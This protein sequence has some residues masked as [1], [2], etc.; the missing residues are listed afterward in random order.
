M[1]KKL[2]TELIHQ[3]PYFKY[4][5]DKFRTDDGQEHNYYYCTTL[6]GAITV[7]VLED[8]RLI[9]VRQYRYVV[10][11]N[12]IEFPCGGIEEGEIPS[13]TIA[14]ELLEETG[15]RAEDF[16]KLGEFSSALS[17]FKDTCSIYVATGLKQVQEPTSEI[18]GS[19]EIL[20]R[21]VD[22]FKDMIKRG[23]IIDGDTLSAWAI[24]QEY[25]SGLI[26][27]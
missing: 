23:E 27:S 26:N 14:R 3:N 11:K 7:P 10:D 20:L 1:I 13:Q 25:V 16:I 17:R 18:T 21:R 6:G 5:Q 12:S 8:G 24:A 22:E 4:Y 2:S 15:Y 19:F 9:L